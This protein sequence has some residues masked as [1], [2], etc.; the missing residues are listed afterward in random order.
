M[1]RNRKSTSK[2]IGLLKGLFV[3]MTHV[4]GTYVPASVGQS[5]EG[6]GYRQSRLDPSFGT[7]ATPLW[8]LKSLE[9]ADPVHIQRLLT[10]EEITEKE[11][12][13]IVSTEETR[14]NAYDHRAR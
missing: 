3:G 13:T 7:T 6:A 5:E 12:E 2:K 4:Y 14:D 9:L 11:Y 8:L 1:D 10:S